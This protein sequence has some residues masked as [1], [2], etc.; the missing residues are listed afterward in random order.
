MTVSLYEV[1]EVSPNA[2]AA[3]IKA[4]Y[5]CLVQQHHPDKNPGDHSAAEHLSRINRAYA[6]LSDSVQRAWYDQATRISNAERRG[7]GRASVPAQS[8][9]S[10]ADGSLRPFAFRRFK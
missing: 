10:K 1:L 6:V 3:V 7:S 8:A 5:R 9:A 4:A 2:S